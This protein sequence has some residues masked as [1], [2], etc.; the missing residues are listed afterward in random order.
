MMVPGQGRFFAVDQRYVSALLMLVF[1]LGTLTLVGLLVGLFM[2][3]L[4]IVNL[5]LDAIIEVSTQIHALYVGGDSFTR[6]VMWLVLLIVL[7]KSGPFLARFF[8]RRAFVR[9]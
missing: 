2:G 5:A 8:R 9:A 4:Y 1:G 7:Y 6:L 3:C